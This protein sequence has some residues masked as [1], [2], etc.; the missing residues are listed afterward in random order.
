MD[1]VRVWAPTRCSYLD[2]TDLDVGAVGD[3]DVITLAV[4]Y[5]QPTNH[6]IARVPERNQLQWKS[7]FLILI[8]D[9][10]KR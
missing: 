4:H 8:K 6:N 7:I 5:R 10:K 9:N 1:T 2:V 3:E